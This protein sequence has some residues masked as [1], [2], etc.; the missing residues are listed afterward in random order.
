MGGFAEYA[1]A[2]PSRL[3][4]KPRNLSFAEAAAVSVAA[5]TAFQ[6]LRDH[7]H[8]QPGQRVLIDGA[9]GGVATFAIQI[10]KALAQRSRLFAA[11]GKVDTARAL[12]ADHVID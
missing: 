12:G 9:S 11:L 10:A 6:A 2:V 7:G 5:T 3:A 8:L 1:C 4:L